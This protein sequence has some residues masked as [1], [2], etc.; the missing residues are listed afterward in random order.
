[1]LEDAGVKLLFA[2]QDLMGKVPDFHGELVDTATVGSL[3]PPETLP[4]G[5]QPDDLMILLYTSGTTGKP[6]GVMLLHQ[7]LANFLHYYCREYGITEADN[8]PAYAS[9][10][11]D[12]CMMDMYPTLISGACLH[13]I[14]EEMR[15]D[16]PGLSRYFDENDISVAFMTTQ[17]GRQFAESMAGKSLRALSV[18][19][20]T[21]VPIAPPSFDFYNVY[22]PTECTILATRFRVDQLYDRVPIGKPLDNTA[23]YVVDGRGRL[24]P[25][26]TAG[27]LCIAGRQVAKGY[28]NRPDLTEEKFVHNPFSEEADYDRMYR[29]GDVVRFLPSGDIDFVGRR[30]FQ[31]KYAASAWS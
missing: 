23:L 17:L 21:L 30:D 12:A 27:E 2:E 16:L 8:I 6:K 29:S 25:V 28:L 20:E 10:G 1:M 7:N 11:F 19:G 31:V 24:A 22:G 3:P 26:G 14:P 9:F 13:I 4:E 18:G 5:P 15:L